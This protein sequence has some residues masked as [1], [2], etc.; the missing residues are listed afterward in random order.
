MTTQPLI[1][2]L[3]AEKQ[4]AASAALAWPERQFVFVSDQPVVDGWDLPNVRI[5][6]GVPAGPW[7]CA[8]AVGPNWVPLCPRWLG[9]DLT[10]PINRVG[11]FR[12]G[13]VLAYLEDA[14]PE[15][16]L[17]VRPTPAGDT[18]VIVKG[19]LR[20]RPDGLLVGSRFLPGEPDD[21]HGCGVL[22]QP[23]LRG[24][25]SYL[26]TGRRSPG[27][28]DMAVA[29]IYSEACARDDVLQ[30]GE[31]VSHDAI[32]RLAM[33]MLEQLDHQGFFTLNWVERDGH[34]RLTS[35][36]PVPRALFGTL[37][38]AGLDL[39]A[40]AGAGVRLARPGGKFTVAIHYSS[41]Q[42]LCA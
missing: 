1:G 4:A 37:R 18:D 29:A 22:F 10:I 23:Y 42:A 28:L 34:V 27:G 9:P 16:I 31:L 39:F 32:A 17:P 33:E 21:P 36:R 25:R 20:H 5:H 38:R 24:A 6:H 7:P 19:D 3:G 2:L 14:F 41:Y 26:A 15:H 40:P 13:R 8:D 35:L 30:A 12:L 11:T